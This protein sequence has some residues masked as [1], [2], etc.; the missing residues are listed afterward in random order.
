MTRYNPSN[1][2]FYYQLSFLKQEQEPWRWVGLVVLTKQTCVSILQSVVI[3]IEKKE[4]CLLV[5]WETAFGVFA[6]CR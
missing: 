3:T 5:Q 2:L 1:E 4:I 6:F